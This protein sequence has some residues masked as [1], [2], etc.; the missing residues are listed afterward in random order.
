M[1]V[2]TNFSTNIYWLIHW[3]IKFWY[4]YLKIFLIHMYT[5]SYRLQIRISCFSKCASLKTG[6]RDNFYFFLIICLKRGRIIC[7][8]KTKCTVPTWSKQQL[9]AMQQRKNCELISKPVLI[10]SPTVTIDCTP[11]WEMR[12]HLNQL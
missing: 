9:C 5:G 8:L 1:G 2:F 7:A 12:R 11:E 3:F 10:I 4:V 6:W